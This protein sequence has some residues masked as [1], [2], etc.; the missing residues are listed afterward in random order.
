M[1]RLLGRGSIYTLSLAVQLSAGMIVVPILTRLLPA[2]DYGRIAIGLV[3]ISFVQILATGGLSEVAARSWFRDDE[4]PAHAR[5]LVLS[6]LPIAVMVGL[7]FDTTG[8]VWARALSLHYDSALRAAVWTGCAGGVLLSAQA[9]LRAA[10]RPWTFVAIAAIASVGAQGLALALTVVYRTPFAYMLGL[11]LGTT[12]AALAALQCNRVLRQRLPS[13]REAQAAMSIGLPVLPHNV[14]VY[15]IAS[16]D[17]LLVAAVLGLA[18]AGRY[19]V[20][21]AVGGLGVTLI[22]AINQAWLPLFLGAGDAERWDVLA[23]TSAAVHRIAVGVSGALALLSPV[24]LIIMA[25]PSYH[26]ASLVPISA[27]V[28]FSAVPYASCSAFFHGLF[29]EGNTKA[30]AV[31]APIAAVVN[32]AMNVFLL[33]LWGLVAAAGATVAA[34]VVFAIAGVWA[35]RSRIGRYGGLLRT[36]ACSWLAAAPAIAFGALLPES[37][38]GLVV[39]VVLAVA[40]LVAVVWPALTLRRSSPAEAAAR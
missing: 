3:V 34:Y 18:A 40:L 23:R 25:P 36:S 1:R 30:M 33:E 29:Y 5:R 13:L 28:A 6:T 16:A 4:G 38:G 20:A 22:T 31:S 39:R 21:Y 27:I 7:L 35:T 26:R 10:D 2:S 15:T 14:A 12:I 32:I 11:G 37:G 8:S 24:A 17:R 9:L 19:Q